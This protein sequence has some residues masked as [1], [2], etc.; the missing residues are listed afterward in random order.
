MHGIGLHWCWWPAICD[1]GGTKRNL[2]GLESRVCLKI[3]VIKE[4]LAPLVE[5]SSNALH[6]C[7][8]QVKDRLS[9]VA[10]WTHISTLFQPFP[11]NLS[12][13]VGRIQC[14]CTSM[15]LRL[16]S[17]FSLRISAFLCFSSLLQSHR[18]AYSSLGAS[19]NT[20]QTQSSSSKVL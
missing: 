3:E 2:Q 20:L 11:P 13:S 8:E 10:G 1:I 5:N 19:F 14:Y 17:S 16:S 18:R 12:L 7:V 4:L 6:Q 9:Q 15:L